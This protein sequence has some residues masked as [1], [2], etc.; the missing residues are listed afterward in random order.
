MLSLHNILSLSNV[1]RSFTVNTLSEYSTETPRFKSLSSI[2][3]LFNNQIIELPLNTLITRNFLTELIKNVKEYYTNQ[4]E[5]DKS[6][7][8]KII[9][10]ITPPNSISADNLISILEDE[11]IIFELDG[12]YKL[13]PTDYR[14]GKIQSSAKG[15]P[16]LVLD[17]GTNLMLN[18][19]T[20]EVQDG[21]YHNVIKGMSLEL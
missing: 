12:I 3:N 9:N 6:E 11:G 7:L 10:K 18:K 8:T 13:M 15:N 1:V 19:E 2:N 14:I 16:Y 4:K 21:T 20:G 17:D 5:S